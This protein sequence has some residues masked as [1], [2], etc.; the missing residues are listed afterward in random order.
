MQNTVKD[1]KVIKYL[2]RLK[3]DKN[4][5]LKLF[6]DRKTYGNVFYVIGIFMAT[7]QAT[8]LFH[9]QWIKYFQTSY[10][11]L[12]LLFFGII[13][14]LYLQRPVDSRSEKLE[15]TDIDIEICVGDFFSL[16][17]TYVIPVN[18]SFEFERFAK[19][20]NTGEK[21]SLI[22]ALVEKHFSD[23]SE[24]NNQVQKQLSKL[25][26]AEEANMQHAA[27]V[28]KYPAGTV[29]RVDW[30]SEAKSNGAYLVATTYLNEYGKSR[31][32]IEY[33]QQALAGLWADVSAKGSPNAIAIPLIGGGH[34]S[35]TETR[36]AIVETI[37]HSF[38]VAVRREKR[39]LT[40]KLYVVISPD[41]HDRNPVDMIHLGHY[42][43]F[44]CSHSQSF[45]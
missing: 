8:S 22:R 21:T 13:F 1:V 17:S 27:E 36:E 15:G 5:R 37:I 4:Y 10:T 18:S 26:P 34:G 42:L 19:K 24:L 30:E 6:K 20:L 32:N 14:S 29:V 3:R 33:T 25:S 31:T 28:K 40:K 35:L 39:K 12:G 11:F 43:S 2:V 41:D 9:H 7:E 44:V 38:V 23:V 45:H 16:E